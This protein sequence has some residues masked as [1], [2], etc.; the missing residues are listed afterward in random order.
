VDD[1]LEDDSSGMNALCLS[2]TRLPNSEVTSLHPR[3]QEDAILLR[4]SCCQ[5][6]TDMENDR[7]L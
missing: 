2:P 5:G 3:E 6:K 7:T 1:I 4:Q